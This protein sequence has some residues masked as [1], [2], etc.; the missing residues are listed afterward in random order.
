MVRGTQEGGDPRWPLETHATLKHYTAYSIETD[1]FGVSENVSTYD[2]FDSFLPQHQAGF[3][4]GK[5]AGVMCS[6]MS[7][8]G[9]PSCAND[10]ILNHMI[11]EV[12]GRPERCG[13]STVPSQT[14][15]LASKTLASAPHYRPPPVRSH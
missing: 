4:Q 6:Y 12:W 10:F 11:R 13:E 15:S 5:A 1:R 3:Q 8:N 7:M 9:V 14:T 2:L